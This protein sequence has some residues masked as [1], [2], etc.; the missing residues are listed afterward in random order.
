MRRRQTG[1]A[2]EKCIMLIVPVVLPVILARADP[3]GVFAPV[4][5]ILLRAAWRWS[6]FHAD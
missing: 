5:A 6:E 1:G 2:A 4:V 3:A